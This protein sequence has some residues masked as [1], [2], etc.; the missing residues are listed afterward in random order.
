MKTPT[1]IHIYRVTECSVVGPYTLAFGF[2]DG[3]RQTIDFR[4][5]LRG[6]LWGPL[7]DITV[8]NAVKIDPEI[9]TIVWP[10]GADWDAGMLHDWQDCKEEMLRMTSAWPAGGN[11]DTRRVA[12]TGSEYGV[13]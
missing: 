5:M 13:P 9:G 1:Q 3:T 10:N 8:F 4:P 12:E 2:D 6:A 7:T 11:S